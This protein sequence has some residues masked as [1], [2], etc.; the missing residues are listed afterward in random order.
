MEEKEKEL[1]EFQ[2]LIKDEIPAI[3]LYSPR[4]TYV[5]ADRIKGIDIK[6]I[7]SPSDRL[8]NITN[9]YIKTKKG[10]K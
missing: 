5:V 2:H 8:N 10:F 6:R 1:K 4:Y 3:F 9:W 7:V